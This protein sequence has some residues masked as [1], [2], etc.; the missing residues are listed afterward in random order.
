MRN[1]GGL[2]HV[3]NSDC[4]EKQDSACILKVVQVGFVTGLVVRY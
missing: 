3:V 1:D 4:E 2:H